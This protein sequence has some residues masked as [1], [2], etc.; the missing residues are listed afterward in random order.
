D[1]ALRDQV[2]VDGAPAFALHLA[3]LE[4]GRLVAVLELGPLLHQKL[5]V[6]GMLAKES[7]IGAQRGG[8]AL[9]RID[10]ALDATVNAVAHPLHTTIRRRE[11]KFALA[12]EIA[13]ERAFA[14]A[15]FVGQELRV[16]VAVA[17]LGEE[18]DGGIEDLFA[19]VDAERIIGLPARPI[20]SGIFHGRFSGRAGG[21]GSLSYIYPNPTQ[22]QADSKPSRSGGVPHLKRARKGE[23]T[24]FV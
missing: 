17:M 15:E 8:D 2:A 16:G 23:R 3:M 14:D 24:R 10:D 6:I 7:E 4:I 21:L 5:D 11:K 1:S 13:I 22:K 19:T 12:G 9:E 20:E 18:F